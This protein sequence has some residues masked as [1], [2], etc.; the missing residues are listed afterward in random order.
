MADDFARYCL[1]QY[2]ALATHR[3]RFDY[4]QSLPTE[5]RAFVVANA[6]PLHSAAPV[7]TAPPSDAPVATSAASP[8]PGT[9]AGSVREPSAA[10][11]VRSPSVV[12]DPHPMGESPRTPIPS[13][14]P[15]PAPAPRPTPP[16]SRRALS[17]A[18]LL[19]P[20]ALPLTSAPSWSPSAVARDRSP[21]APAAV[22][23]SSPSVASHASIVPNNAITGDLS[24]APDTSAADASFITPEES[25]R[26]YTDL[27]RRCLNGEIPSTIR[28][29]FV[30]Y[31]ARDPGRRMFAEDPR[32]RCE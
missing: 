30:A 6:A 18:P 31:G 25:N 9:P 27:A 19:L 2:N 26:R 23:P 24:L 16:V 17:S 22:A 1:A 4:Y 5:V 21:I 3:Q 32:V 29:E 20:S 12:R 8:A 14:R 11:S 10:P 7:S 15:S 28:A 13:A